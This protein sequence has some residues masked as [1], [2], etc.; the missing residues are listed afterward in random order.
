[1]RRGG[2]RAGTGAP[3]MNAA[4]RAPR[5]DLSGGA[6]TAGA[7]VARRARQAAAA[8]ETELSMRRDAGS[9]FHPENIR[10]QAAF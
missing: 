6:T 5:M 10:R 3:A 4:G 7:S 9:T 1:V 8:L 2:R